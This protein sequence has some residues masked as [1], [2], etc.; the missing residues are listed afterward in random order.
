MSGKK[1][2]ITC[3]GIGIGLLILGAFLARQPGN[4]D[5]QPL[6][7]LDKLPSSLPGVLK[8]EP[9]SNSVALSS[10]AT[11]RAN[12]SSVGVSNTVQTPV[13]LGFVELAKDMLPP[14]SY[15]SLKS[16]YATDMK[17]P[18]NY[19]SF[20]MAMSPVAEMLDRSHQAKAYITVL[21]KSLTSSAADID[22]LRMLGL[23]YSS[24]EASDPKREA[25]VLAAYTNYAKDRDAMIRLAQLLA[26]RRETDKAYQAILG[27][28]SANP[29]TAI[30]SLVDGIRM[31]SDLDDSERTL[32]LCRQ[33]ASDNHARVTS[34]IYAGE[35]LVKFGQTDE[36]IRA[37]EAASEKATKQ[38]QKEDCLLGL[39]EARIVQNKNPE[40]ITELKRLSTAGSN[41]VIQNKALRLIERLLVTK[42]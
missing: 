37:F 38:Y 18:D 33:V 17:L 11:T 5:P 26:G 12:G 25:E 32:A 29:E 24:S 19:T 40:A 27:A 41:T 8:S 39:C 14:A 22:K 4:P 30:S 23:L 16:L 3:L 6:G 35:N 20:A 10:V 13:A 34:L 42:K 7:K 2:S 9:P 28:A 15:A 21:E 36:A 31:F 1:L